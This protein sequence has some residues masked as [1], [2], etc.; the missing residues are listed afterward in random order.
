MSQDR[1]AR[2]RLLSITRPAGIDP[3]GNYG[4]SNGGLV[5]TFEEARKFRLTFGHFSGVSLEEI[6]MR[7]GLNYL[8]N[9]KDADAVPALE[10]AAMNAYLSG[11][12]VAARLQMNKRR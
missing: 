9:L 12:E 8:D 1:S 11:P 4:R 3:G 2:L 5:M 10:R 7:G 6:D